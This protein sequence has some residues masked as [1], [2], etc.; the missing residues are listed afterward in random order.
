MSA[1]PYGPSAYSGENVGGVYCILTELSVYKKEEKSRMC[2][3]GEIGC[4]E[5]ALR[6]SLNLL[7]A[8]K[9]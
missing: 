5:A 1:P 2:K 6:R 4:V 9:L 3:A 8:V 7:C